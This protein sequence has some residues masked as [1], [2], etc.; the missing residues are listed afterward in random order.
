MSQ[1]NRSNVPDNK[2]SGDALAWV[3]IF[4]LMFALPP[5]GILLLILKLRGYAKP[6]RNTFDRKASSGAYQTSAHANNRAYQANAYGQAG[7]WQAAYSQGSAN[8]ST[9]QSSHKSGTDS[10]RQSSSAQGATD[11]ARQ[12]ARNVEKT[13]REVIREVEATAREIKS[14]FSEVFRETK[15][16]YT[17]EKKYAMTKAFDAA[18]L[19]ISKASE[20]KAK[21]KKLTPLE[22]KTGKFVSTMILL[23]SI[24]LFVLG[25]NTIISSVRGF[26]LIS[27][28]SWAELSLGML[29]II[30]SIIAFCT[31]NIGVNR[32]A[33]FKKNYA[34]IGGRDIVPMQD[35]ARATGRSP[36]KVARDVQIMINEGYLGSEAYIDS[37]LDA[38]VLSSV[39]ADAARNATKAAQES[40]DV[41]DEIPENQYMAIIMELR[42]LKVSIADIAISDK[43][44][45]IEAVTAKIFR[46]VEEDSTKLPQI[47]RFMGYYLPTT[48]K[49]LRSYALLEKQGITG[50]N[51]TA[52]KENI[53]RILDTLAIG[54]E[55]Q[56]D[57]LFRSDAI[58]IA[59]DIDVLENL[60]QQDGLTGEKPEMKTMESSQ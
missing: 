47:R 59:A 36:G 56:L 12:T 16:Q 31:R 50:E 23:L 42:E 58:D 49:L 53:G 7:A 2:I 51:I 19:E 1:S 54:F 14:E 35:I 11:S 44:D 32:I 52:A 15:P 22:K 5:I 4:V 45:R 34:V 28:G 37:E 60:M 57:Q 43:I 27:M 26:P 3:F 30:G 21:K 39:A 6:A 48:Q 29:Y 13:V 9:S 38:L 17:G 25:V 46:I 40:L 18:A 41:S 10:S 24:A 8:Y 33:R 20:K 55:Q